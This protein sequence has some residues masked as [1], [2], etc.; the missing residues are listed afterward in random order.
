MKNNNPWKMP[1]WIKVWPAR[2]GLMTF[3]IWYLFTSYKM[4]FSDDFK[5][6]EFWHF[7]LL[8]GAFVWGLAMIVG[9]I[10]LVFGGFV[11][12]GFCITYFFENIIPFIW[13][14]F[15]KKYLKRDSSP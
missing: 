7:L 15:D 5:I 6:T 11:L 12:A 1:G 13:N 4:A 10:G 14:G 9:G 8:P 3:G 2:I